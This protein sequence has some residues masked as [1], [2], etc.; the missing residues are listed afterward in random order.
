MRILI[1]GN[2]GSGKSTLAGRCAKI[3]S[4]PHFD[5][6]EIA[7]KSAGVRKEISESIGELDA[8][9]ASHGSWVIEGCY[10]S[11]IREAAKSATDLVFLNPGI[12][13]CQKNCESRPWEPHKYDSKEAQDENLEMLLAWVADYEKRTDEFS[14]QAHKEIFESFTGKKQELKTNFESQNMSVEATAFSR[15]PH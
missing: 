3:L 1:Y 15:N 4:V 5:L 7:W 12:E 13:A 10:G 14:H 2:S 6:D 8:F 9:I 11:L